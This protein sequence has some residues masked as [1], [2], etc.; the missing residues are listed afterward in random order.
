[1]TARSC[2]IVHP[3]LPRNIGIPLS[4]NS[5][6]LTMVTGRVA[7]SLDPPPGRGDPIEPAGAGVNASASEESAMSYHLEGSLLEVCNCNIL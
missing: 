4:R 5:S 7:G 1:M 2:V 3:P 6:F